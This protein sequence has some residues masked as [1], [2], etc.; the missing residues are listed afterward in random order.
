MADRNPNIEEEA[1]AYAKHIEA[2]AGLNTML[3][4]IDNYNQWRYSRNLDQERKVFINATCVAMLLV[5][6]P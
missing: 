2:L 1:P 6:T 5:P 4:W 3:V